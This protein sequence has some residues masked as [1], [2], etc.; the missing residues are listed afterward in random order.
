MKASLSWWDWCYYKG[1]WRE[2]AS[3]GLLSFYL[4]PDEDTAGSPSLNA[5]DLIF[6]FPA[7]RTVSQ[8]ISI[9]FKFSFRCSDRAAQ[10]KLRQWGN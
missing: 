10:N 7:S 1:G 3:P 2:F 6:D 9:Y 8:Y 4:L 5:D